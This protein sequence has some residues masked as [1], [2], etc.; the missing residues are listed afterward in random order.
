MTRSI[1]ACAGEPDREREPPPRSSVYP[2]VCGGAASGKTKGIPLSGLSPRVRGSRYRSDRP[3]AAF[4][5]IPACAGE[6]AGPDGFQRWNPVYPRVCGG[7][8]SK[9]EAQRLADGLSPRVRGSRAVPP[10]RY[11]M[12]RSIPACAGEPTPADL[13]CPAPGVYPRVCGGARSGRLLYL[14]Y[15]GLSPRV[16]GSPAQFVVF[17]FL[18]WSIPA[19]AGE[20]RSV[21][22][23]GLSFRVYP[24]VCGGAWKSGARLRCRRGLSPR[25]RGSLWIDTRRPI[26][27]G[28]IPACAGEPDAFASPCR[29]PPVYPRVCGGACLASIA[30]FSWRGLSPRVRGS[31]VLSA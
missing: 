22:S 25:V 7:A 28:S 12:T 2:R 6:P 21:S 10:E 3:L 14:I 16:R 23:P 20:P 11:T 15:Q 30:A 31:R 29:V 5:S 8:D 26:S 24:R 19:C 4:R 9:D 17:G 27:A 18:V 13:R 1:P